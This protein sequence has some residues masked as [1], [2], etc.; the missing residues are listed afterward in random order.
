M[1]KTCIRDPLG[2]DVAFDPTEEV[3]RVDAGG[4]GGFETLGIE[5]GS[6][7]GGGPSVGPAWAQGGTYS[8]GHSNAEGNSSGDT[9][10]T[11]SA[12]TGEPGAGKPQG[13]HDR[14]K[15]KALVLIQRERER[16]VRDARKSEAEPNPAFP[17]VAP[18]QPVYGPV[19]FP[20]EWFQP[21]SPKPDTD[22][23]SAT[24]K[25]LHA[26]KLAED[27]K[28]HAAYTDA[29]MTLLEIPKV[30]DEWRETG[31]PLPPVGVTQWGQTTTIAR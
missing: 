26:A 20:A 1:A 30:R 4:S 3:I 14:T 2:N 12:G 16:M 23:K 13:L 18:D 15:A 17:P 9:G 6:G 29:L 19:C 21:P 28:R 8:A 11:P 10:T 5:F 24:V 27:A 7:G 31:Q 25:P 22:V